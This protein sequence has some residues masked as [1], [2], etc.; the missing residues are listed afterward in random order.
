MEDVLLHYPTPSSA[1]PSYPY[2]TNSLVYV[3]EPANGQWSLPS[4]G[5]RLVLPSHHRHH[6]SS[7]PSSSNKQN[8]ALL[9]NHR[10]QQHSH[11]L[12][13]LL[14]QQQQQQQPSAYPLGLPYTTGQLQQVAQQLPTHP[15]SVLL[16]TALSW[17]HLVA[18]HLW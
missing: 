15:L 13:S 1:A 18:T 11:L 17:R 10:Q 8:V 7:P 12:P 14:Q 16:L 4:L 6:P 9:G 3:G 5:V 2:D